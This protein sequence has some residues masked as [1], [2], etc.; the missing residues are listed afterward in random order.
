MSIGV[1]IKLLHESVHHI[2]TIE[3]K[4]GEQFQ[5]NLAEAED[6]MNV[7]LDDVKMTKRNGKEVYFEQVYI[8]GGQIRFVVIPEQF[9]TAPYLKHLKAQ[10]KGKANVQL[11]EQAR[12][13]RDKVLPNIPKNKK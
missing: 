6:N 10:A 11:R 9:K 5:G 13:Y 3:I 7:R 2:V 8:R 12:K 1:P 4:T